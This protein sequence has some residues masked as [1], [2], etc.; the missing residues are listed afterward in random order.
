[1]KQVTDLQRSVKALREQRGMTQQQVA[2]KSGV[3]RSMVGRLEMC[4]SGVDAGTLERV[5]AALGYRMTAEAV[6]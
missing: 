6:K 2:D 5:L 4:R 1:M 3:A